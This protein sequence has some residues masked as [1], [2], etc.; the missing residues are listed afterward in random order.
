MAKK[1][2]RKEYVSQFGPTIGDSIRLA[3]TD[4]YIKIEKDLCA[5]GKSVYGEELKFGEGKVFRDG[6]G[7]NSVATREDNPLVMDL[8]ITNATIL[9]YTGIIK[10]DIGIRDGKIAAIGHAGNPFLT[11]GI[12]MI[13]GVATDALSGEGMILT[14]GAVEVHTH[15][16][17]PNQFKPA[18]ESGTTTL[19]GGGT[20]PVEGS[21]ATTCTPGSWNIKRM[22]EALDE[23]PLNFGVIG[24]AGGSWSQP[25]EEELRAGACA[26]KIHEDFSAT[27]STI[28]NALK[29]ADEYDVQVSIHTDSL[30]EEGFYEHSVNAIGGR[31]IH[32]F[33]SEGAGGGHAPDVMR[34]VSNPNVIPSSTNPTNPATVDS[35]PEQ[36]DMLMVCHHLDPKI[37]EDLALGESRIREST[38]LAEDVLHDLGAISIMSADSQAMGRI[39]ETVMRTWQVA[40]HM[41]RQVGPLEIKG[42]GKDSEYNDNL[43][44]KRYI[45]K[46]TINPAI[47]N[48]VSTYVGS[49]EVGKYADLVLWDPKFFGIKPR[50][51]IKKGMVALAA[52]GEGNGS[53]ATCEPVTYEYMFA[54]MGKAASR[55]SIAFV[56]KAAYEGKIK[57]EL[58]LEKEVLPV[59][60]VRKLSKKD[61]ILNDATPEVHIDP[62]TFIVKIDGKEMKI[63][64]D[65]EIAM[66]QRY[67]LF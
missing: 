16:I 53:L 28:D 24:K 23:Y 66:N 33:H 15:F 37:P 14:A 38:I 39:G 27:R 57:E 34:I 49:I 2:S 42:L 51:V 18:L 60:G 41:K 25:A 20:G 50:L 46:Y 63:E 4:L 13:A 40:D 6:F 19:F 54:G 61:M 7:Q 48:G 8:I 55:Q 65:E 47:A 10:A 59:F 36:L 17:S 3:D 22:L 30:N 64:P 58:G 45:A 12:D 29:V 44:A 67:L 21:L 35:V 9:D 11:D 43:R 31:T 1:I 56:S 32:T 5:T 26:L 62:Q 52:M